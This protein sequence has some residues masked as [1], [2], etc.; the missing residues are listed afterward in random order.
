[1]GIPRYSL[2][3]LAQQFWVPRWCTR[4]TW[5]G[6]SDSR[7]RGQSVYVGTRNSALI[8]QTILSEPTIM[9]TNDIA[10]LRARRGRASTRNTAKCL[11]SRPASIRGRVRLAT[12]GRRSPVSSADRRARSQPGSVQGLR[13][14]LAIW[15]WNAPP[16]PPGRVYGSC[17]PETV[18]YSLGHSCGQRPRSRCFGSVE[19]ELRILMG[20]QIARASLLS[21]TKVL[22]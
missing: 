5:K 3:V 14:G 17:W 7:L 8:G 2:L 21:T 10:G 11:G 4:G 9:A 18:Q 16:A 15:A 12:L 22:D 20:N 1:L 19:N 13:T 6:T